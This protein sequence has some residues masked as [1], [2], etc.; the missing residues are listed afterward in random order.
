MSEKFWEDLYQKGDTQWEKGEASPGL[1]DFLKERPDLP[2]GTVLV[3]GCGFGHDVRTWAKEG[4]A[5]TGLDIA[6]S[7][8]RL[9]QERTPQG[10]NATFKLGN[11]L[12][13]EPF[14]RFDYLFEHTLFCAIQPTERDTYVDALKRWLKPDG[15]YVAVFYMIPDEDGP[16]FGTTREEIRRRFAGDFELLEDWVPRSYPNR[17]DLEWMTV[18]KR[19]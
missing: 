4:F 12:A 3:P 1:V 14:S 10:L 19:K 2:K 6:P 17:T 9:S 8:N 16:P 5:A 7:S 11:F 15:T 18:W 13:D